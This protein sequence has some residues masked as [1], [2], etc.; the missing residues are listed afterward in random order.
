LLLSLEETVYKSF[1]VENRLDPALTIRVVEA[2][3]A[4]EEI[5]ADAPGA[6]GEVTVADAAVE[7]HEIPM[8]GVAYMVVGDDH[9]ARENRMSYWD[10]R[11]AEV[12]S[13]AI[14]GWL[15]KA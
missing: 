13:R 14:R 2:I 7:L 10:Y 5:A 4:D 1:A 6:E 8:L 11:G 12:D 15:D 9:R 3:V